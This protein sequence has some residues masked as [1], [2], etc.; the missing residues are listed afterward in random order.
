[1]DNIPQP[2]Q[3][4]EPESDPESDSENSSDDKSTQG[5][6]ILDHLM[7]TPIPWE[8]K[9]WHRIL[10]HSRHDDLNQILIKGTTL[11]ACSDASVDTANFSTFSWLL[12]GDRVLWQGEGII[13]DL[14]EDVYSGQSKAFGVLTLLRFLSNYLSNYPNAYPTTPALT[15]YC[16][17]QGVLDRIHRLPANKPLQSRDTTA[18]DYDVYI[19][20]RSALININPV[21]VQFCHVKGHQ[22]RL[23][24]QQL[25]LPARLKHQMRQEHGGLPQSG[26]ET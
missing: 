19:A 23:Q 4:Q 7:S 8:S 2:E 22:D 16:N 3:H 26:T 6:T 21:N 11:I 10:C 1:V 15:V 20:I 25:S 13:P 18:N 24:R 12:Y 14:V 17:N 9:L 5:R